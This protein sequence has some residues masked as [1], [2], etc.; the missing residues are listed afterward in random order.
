MS[1]RVFCI[2]FAIFAILMLCAIN[3]AAKPVTWHLQHVTF[4]DGGTA[5]GSFVYDVDAGFNGTYSNISITTTAG[6]TMTADTF[7][8]VDPG[9]VSYSIRFFPVTTGGSLTGTPVL[10]LYFVSPL[11]DA[12]GSLALQTSGPFQSLWGLCGDS[13][14][15]FIQNPVPIVDVT[16]GVVTAVVAGDSSDYFT[17]YYSNANTANAPDATV[18]AINDGGNGGNLYASIY[19]FDDS[20]ELTECCS[21]VITPDGLLSESVNKNLTANPLTGIKPTR[22]VIKIISSP[23]DN[24]YDLEYN[25]ENEPTPGLRG[26]ATHVQ[27]LASGYAVTETLLADSNM[28]SAEEDLLGALCFFDS[29]LSGKPCTCTAED[30]DF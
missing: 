26:W 25:G 15:S 14:C 10:V 28:G 1:K 18:R 19:V 27:K 21:C 22:G 7:A 12:G 20:E 3:A 6:T 17:T 5:S 16:A 24:P 23:D 13:T 2:G 30:A 11:T 29:K 4:A 9:A 8:F